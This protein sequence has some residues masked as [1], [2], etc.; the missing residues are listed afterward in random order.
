MILPILSYGNSILKNKSVEID[1]SYP[2]LDKLINDMWE[3][4][5]NA[6][7]VG[8]A[9]PQIG[10]QI[11]LFIIDAAPFFDESDITDFELKNMKRVFINPSIKLIDDKT[12]SFNEGCLSI[13]DIRE[14]IERQDLIK[15]N[16][17]DEKFNYH[18]LKFNGILARV[19]LH[20]YDHIEGILFTDKISK[21]KRTLIQKKLNKISSGNIDV[22]Y[23][24]KFS[25]K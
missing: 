9:A 22:K 14:D 2:N 12:C 16:F 23:P 7:G 4:M 24:M 19:I 18:S 10:K 20:E 8:L 5:Y 11:R 3:T 6:E 13:P 17:F 21:F 25:K 15:I 1:S